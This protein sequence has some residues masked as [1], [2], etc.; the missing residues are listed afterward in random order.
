MIHLTLDIEPVP[1]GRPR[2]DRNGHAYTPAK[3]RQFELAL[4][5]MARLL[6]KGEPMT[7]AIMAQIDCYLIPPKRKVRD[8]PIAKPDWDNLGTSVCDAGNGILWHDDSQL[9]DVRVRKHYDWTARKG[10]IEMRI[11]EMMSDGAAIP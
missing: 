6:W 8:L 9:V 3:T 2:F 10:R 5:A 7:G 4:R 1:K 11:S